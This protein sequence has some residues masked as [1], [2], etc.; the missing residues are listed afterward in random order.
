MTEGQN[1]ALTYINNCVSKNLHKVVVLDGVTGS[2]KTEVYLRA[3]SNVLAKGKNAI[4]L[5]PEISLT[6]QTVSRFYNR[7]GNNI[8]V[9]HSKISASERANQI[10]KIRSGNVRLVIG[11]RSAI[12]C[13]LENIGLIVIDEEHENSYKQDKTPRYKTVDCAEYLAKQNDAVLVLGSATPSLESIYNCQTKDDWQLIKLPQRT[14]NAQMPK[15]DIVDMGLEFKNG[16]KNLFSKQLENSICQ[17]LKAGHKVLLFHNRR[18]FA[19]YMFCRSCGYTPKCPNC[20]TTLTYH[21]RLIVDGRPKQMLFCHHCGHLEH[22]PITCPDCNS[23]YIAK[24]GAG[25]QSVEEQLEALIADNEITDARVVRMDADT[26]NQALGHQKCLEEFAKPGPAILLGTQMIA[27]GL[28]FDDVTLVGVVLI[29]TNLS[30][31]DF[32]CAERTF[33]LILQVA[34]RAGRANLPGK[35]IVQTY[36]PLDTSIVCAANYEKDNFIAQEFAKRKLM[37]YPPYSSLVNFIISGTKEENVVEYSNQVQDCLESYIQKNS[38]SEWDLLPSA[39][40]VLSKIRNQFRYHILLKSNAE[41]T[42]AHIDKALKNL[43]IKSN[44]KLNIDVDPVS[45][46]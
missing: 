20:S 8:A 27:K 17:H 4:V 40:C 10:N 28:D 6:P 30:L 32:R 42:S 25:T 39:P 33:D 16:S 38:L 24:Y 19:N 23:P 12:F 44:V 14:N 36:Y 34:G 46:F 41:N 26:T 31:P 1:D 7:F 45:L 15:I 29:D 18:G 37:N 43:K 2:G 21:Q 9:M 11:A 22:V 3:I 5:V 35:V 13:P